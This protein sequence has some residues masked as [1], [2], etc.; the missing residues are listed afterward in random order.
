M[1]DVSLGGQPGSGALAVG[2]NAMAM[3]TQTLTAP[4][5]TKG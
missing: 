3:G 1:E 5:K 2:S 4:S